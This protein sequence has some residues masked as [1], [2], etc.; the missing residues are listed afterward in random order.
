MSLIVK[1]ESDLISMIENDEWMMEILKTVS[2]LDLPDWWICA[3]FVRSKIW[4]AVHGF[5]TRTPLSDIDVIYYDDTNRCESAEKKIE[6]KLH[7]LCAP[8]PWSAKNEARMHKVN[9]IE[10]YTSAADAIAKFPETATALG[11]KLDKANKVILLAPHGIEDAVNGCIKP[12]PYFKD[13]K[14][15]MIILDNRLNEKKW[16]S[17][18]PQLTTP[19]QS[20]N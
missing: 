14:E 11:V 4:V 13:N 20:I 8:I 6:A 15:R 19:K 12:T 9:K 1:S 7:E 18:W 3:G 16:N 5:D 17:I 10:P 2:K